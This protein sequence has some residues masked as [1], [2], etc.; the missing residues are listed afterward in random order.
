MPQNIFEGL[1]EIKEQQR[2]S[3]ENISSKIDELIKLENQKNNQGTDLTFER[4]QKQLA[5]AY[6]P[7]ELIDD[8]Y[9]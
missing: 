9:F 7:S 4:M 1:E 5:K 8:I 3:E 6:Y 2:Q